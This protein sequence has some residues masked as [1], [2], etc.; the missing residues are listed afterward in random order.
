MGFV[1]IQLALLATLML[2]VAATAQHNPEGLQLRISPYTVHFSDSDE[3]KDAMGLS[4]ARVAADG[5][6]AGG[7]VFRNSF[8]QPCVYGFVGREY[9]NPFGWANTY[10]SWSAG[11]VYGY[12]PPFEDKVPLN[13]NGFS[14]VFVPSVGYRLRPDL[15]LEVGM[16][17]TSGLSFSVV[18]DL[19]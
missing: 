1:R 11:V 17:G 18:M 12:K 9:Q 5:W 14:P 8:G 16:L 2:P 6:M 10:W 3:H 19:R 15:A 7:A 4:L 13:K